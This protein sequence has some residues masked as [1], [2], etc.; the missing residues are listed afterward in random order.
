[1]KHVLIISLVLAGLFTQAQN[2]STPVVKPAVK[3]TTHKNTVSIGSK[4]PKK[5]VTNPL[6]KGVP[7]QKTVAS[8][9][10]QTEE[11]PLLTID[12]SLQNQQRENVPNNDNKPG[13]LANHGTKSS[14][15]IKPVVKPAQP[16][17]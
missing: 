6:K 17:Q 5:S 1:M 2:N 9:V 8:P 15:L 13:K 14:L 7:P 12:E 10:V 11:K 4:L 16:P 3:S